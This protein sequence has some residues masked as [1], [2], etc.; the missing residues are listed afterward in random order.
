MAGAL[1]PALGFVAGALT[2]LSP[3]VL[4][5]VPIVLGNALQKN[6][7][8]PLALAGGLVASFTVT[9]LVLATLGDALGL[10]SQSVSGVGAI[11]LILGGVFLL[12]KRVQDGV[13]RAAA[14]LVN[15]AGNRQAGLERFGLAGQALIGALL[16]IVWSPCVG[17]TLGAA[18]LLA[19]QGGNLAAAATVMLAFALG[20]AAM[21]LLVALA[22][23]GVMARRRGALLSAGQR[24]KWL[25]GGAMAAVGVLI[26][27]GGDHWIEGQLLALSPAWLT[28]L[29]TAF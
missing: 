14:P 12:S 7:L 9:G 13:A 21:L 4:P 23:R 20:I 6:R 25:L 2:I 5:L 1:N 17:P 10:S 24:G 18:T 11:A 22:A 27:S 29:T 3:C 16:G 19:A 26:L 28:N 8:A 15:W